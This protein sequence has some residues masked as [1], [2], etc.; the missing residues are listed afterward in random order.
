MAGLALEGQGLQQQERSSFR[1]G[2]GAVG[3][4]IAGSGDPYKGN[5]A[6]LERSAQESGDYAKLLQEGGSELV[7]PITQY[8]KALISGDRTALMAATQPERRK[9][10]DQYSTRKELHREL[11]ASRRWTVER[12]DQ[13]RG[14]RSGGSLRNHGGA[15]ARTRRRKAVILA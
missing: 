11:C 4:L 1:P 15:C 6:G 12:A 10:I 8:Y 5:I 7:N 9:V 14:E 2:V 13:P 3:Q